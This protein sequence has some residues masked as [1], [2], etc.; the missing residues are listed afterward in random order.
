LRRSPPRRAHAQAV[1]L[2]LS[3]DDVTRRTILIVDDDEAVATAMLMLF[4]VLGYR[5]VAGA[6][7]GAV[8]D[9]L[10]PRDEPAL[11]ISDWHFAGARSGAD[12]IGDFRKRLDREIPAILITGDPASAAQAT[13]SLSSCHVMSKPA[14]TDELIEL[15]ERLLANG[16]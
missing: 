4:E 7:L 3:R 13:Q 5:A 15:V 10:G 1:A 16:P 9:R 11:L 6:D 12:V 8:C 14:D 2:G